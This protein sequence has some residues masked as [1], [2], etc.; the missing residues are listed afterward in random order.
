MFCS[1]VAACHVT[2]YY[3]YGFCQMML[4]KFDVALDAFQSILMYASRAIKPLSR[5]HQQDLINKKQDQM[6]ALLA[7]CWTILGC[8]V[9]LDTGVAE[10]VEEKHHDVVHRARR[11]DVSSFEEL[12]VQSCPKFLV[13]QVPPLTPDVP[14]GGNNS[15]L[16]PL[17][18]QQQNFMQQVRA[19]AS[20]PRIRS[21]L[22]L[23]P[24]LTVDK[25]AQLLQVK[26]EECRALLQ[27]YKQNTHP[28]DPLTFQMQGDNI[29]V[30]EVKQQTNVLQP[31]LDGIKRVEQLYGR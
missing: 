19:R 3:Y 23:Y 1:Q 22:R 21:Y 11:G 4:W 16:E 9:A 17:K 27:S 8:P 6:V 10:T 2:L 24:V 7:L 13:A 26:P 5:P 18:Q 29:T 31:L 12:F 15:H 28:S 20:V 25:L 14:S 30:S